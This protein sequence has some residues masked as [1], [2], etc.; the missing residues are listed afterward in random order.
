M[1]VRVL[2]DVDDEIGSCRVA[3]R[4]VE[5]FIGLRFDFVEFL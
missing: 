1:L 3:M 5:C 4:G 2:M